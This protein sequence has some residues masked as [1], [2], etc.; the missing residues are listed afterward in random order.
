[1]RI[2]K[3]ERGS[4]AYA[5][6]PAR[7]LDL[8]DSVIIAHCNTAARRH[9]HEISLPITFHKAAQKRQIASD[10]FEGPTP[11][12]GLGLGALGNVLAPGPSRST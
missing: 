1:M 6:S 7:R 11:A 5:D 8:Q 9:D 2:A 4:I 3:S 10:P 12:G